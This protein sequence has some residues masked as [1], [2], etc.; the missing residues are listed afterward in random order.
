MEEMPDRC[1]FFSTAIRNSAS[2]G[3]CARSRAVHRMSCATEFPALKSRLPSL[4]TNSYLLATVGS[5][6]LSV[7][8]RYIENQEGV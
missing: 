3:W 8:K 1:T 6:P 7:I 4:W 2:I 5:A